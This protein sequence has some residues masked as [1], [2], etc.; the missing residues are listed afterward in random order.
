MATENFHFNYFLPNSFNNNQ[1][2]SAANFTSFY[3]FEYGN[4]FTFNSGFDALN[5]VQDILNTTKPGY[6]YGLQLELFVGKC[7]LL[8]LL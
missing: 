1:Q 7:Q 6:N 5:D 3:S 8:V 2:C 4:C